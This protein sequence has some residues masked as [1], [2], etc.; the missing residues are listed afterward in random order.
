MQFRFKF[1]V[2]QYMARSCVQLHIESYRLP[3]SAFP[4]SASMSPGCKVESSW[5]A[6][7][8][9]FY[10]HNFGHN[11]SIRTHVMLFYSETLRVLPP[12]KDSCFCKLIFCSSNSLNRSCTMEQRWSKCIK[13]PWRL[14]S[15]HFEKLQ[16]MRPE[17]LVQ[18]LPCFISE[19]RPARYTPVTMQKHMDTTIKRLEEGLGA[20]HKVL[21]HWNR[22]KHIEPH[23][24]TYIYNVLMFWLFSV[25]LFSDVPRIWVTSQ[26]NWRGLQTGVVCQGGCQKT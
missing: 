22:L 18:P 21:Q 10:G 12:S 4:S 1:L 25:P 13:M 15:Q 20:W 17:T 26:H 2:L 3:G 19:S 24:H 9:C 23:T 11:A 5:I 16:A 8:C 14:D 6:I 7:Y